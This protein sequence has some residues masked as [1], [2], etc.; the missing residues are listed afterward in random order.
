MLF[1]FVCSLFDKE[2]AYIDRLIDE[3]IRNNSAWNQRF[4]IV[5]QMGFTADVLEKE[6]RYVMKCIDKAKRNESA[7]NY[8]KGILRQT[9]TAALG[10][11]PEVVEFCEN[12]YAN[13]CRSPHLLTY[14][15]DLYTERCFRYS[16]S[17]EEQSVYREKVC[18]LC[19]E[20]ATKYDV[21]RKK[22]WLYIGEQLKIQFDEG[23]FDQPNI[24]K[25]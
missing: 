20:L 5:K 11:N 17:K 22:Y 24:V 25:L 15:L 18:L 6:C 7:W 13:E 23:L 2:L 19:E 1:F 8:L 10:A 9:P 12:L 3:D 4:F 16:L 14:L 21:I